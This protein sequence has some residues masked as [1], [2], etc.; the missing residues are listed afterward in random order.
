VSE[1]GNTIKRLRQ[2]LGQTMAEFSETIGT[3]QST[4]SRYE[5]GRIPPSKSILILLLLLA[6]EDEKPEILKALGLENTQAGAEL[7]LS[8]HRLNEARRT[9]SGGARLSKADQ[10]LA[11]FVEEAAKIAQSGIPVD[12]CLVEL[13]HL[14][15][16]HSSNRKGLRDSLAQM[17]PYFKYTAIR[18]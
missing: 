11:A 3:Q 14:W 8:K 6:D 15:R 4:I 13:L 10:R 18:G 17:L 2:R 12:D 9:L 1:L 16:T 7:H 5:S